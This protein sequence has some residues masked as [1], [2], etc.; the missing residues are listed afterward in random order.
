MKKLLLF[1]L[2]L[3]STLGFGQTLSQAF[4]ARD[5]ISQGIYKEHNSLKSNTS[6]VQWGDTIVSWC[7]HRIP[8]NGSTLMPWFFETITYVNG[9]M[10]EDWMKYYYGSNMTNF[11]YTKELYTYINNGYEVEGFDSA[12]SVNWTSGGRSKLLNVLGVNIDS[13]ISY[14]WNAGMNKYIL[15][16]LTVTYKSV[17][18]TDSV[19][20]SYDPVVQMFASKEVTYRSNGSIDSIINYDNISGWVPYNR[21]IYFGNYSISSRVDG[22]YPPV[23]FYWDASRN[24]IIATVNYDQSGLQTDSSFSYFTGTRIDS[25]ANFDA[26]NNFTGA[27]G[28]RYSNAVHRF[29]EWDANQVVTNYYNSYFNLQGDYIGRVW[30]NINGS[31][32]T[33]VGLCAVYNSLEQVEPPA[34][35]VQLSP[36]P[37]FGSIMLAG[38]FEHQLTYSIFD[39][40]G[41]ELMLGEAYANEPI[42]VSQLNSGTYIFKANGEGVDLSLRIVKL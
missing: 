27:L 41:R 35:K 40:S 30:F 11:S 39:L 32:R 28:I 15:D 2:T 13:S 24:F 14:S 38:Q 7:A 21:S 29:F 6:G 1:I 19:K 9:Q 17:G 31:V 37:T 42:D 4:E 3:S 25:T 10:T 5:D 22:T 36:N 33:K 12:D 20:W 16:N 18:G 23:K 26:S 8:T 34:T